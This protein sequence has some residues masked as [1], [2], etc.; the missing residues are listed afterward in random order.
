MSILAVTNLKKTC[1]ACPA[2]WEGRSGSNSIYIRYRHGILRADVNGVTV[3]E[4]CVGE[5]LSG[6]M[7]TNHMR[8]HLRNTF[9]F[10][11]GCDVSELR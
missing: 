4:N 3:Y 9:A 1:E 8:R 6:S 2:Q 10:R 11:G 7:E 5:P